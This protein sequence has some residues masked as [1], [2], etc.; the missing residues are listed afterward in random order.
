MT[1]ERSDSLHLVEVLVVIQNDV[2]PLDNT[3]RSLIV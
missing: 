2:G 3:D 1:L